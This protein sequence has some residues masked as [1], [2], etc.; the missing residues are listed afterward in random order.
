MA[1]VEALKVE[2]VKVEA[3]V[4]LEAGIAAVPIAGLVPK[5]EV[6]NVVASDEKAAG[7]ISEAADVPLTG[8]S[9]SSSKNLSPTV[10]ISIIRLTSS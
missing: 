3:S 1:K 10:C 2:V 9:I 6:A 4:V 8:P 7:L 5:T